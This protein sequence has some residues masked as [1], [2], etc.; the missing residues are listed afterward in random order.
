MVQVH[1]IDVLVDL[2]TKKNKTKQKSKEGKYMYIAFIKQ[3]RSSLPCFTHR[4]KDILLLARPYL[5][6]LRI[7]DRQ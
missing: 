3:S 1:V 2:K 7:V 5:P 6:P 4:R